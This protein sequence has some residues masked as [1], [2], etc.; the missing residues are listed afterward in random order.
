MQ[1]R[2]SHAFDLRPRIVIAFN[3]NAGFNSNLPSFE[4]KNLNR[5]RCGVKPLF[6]AS[7]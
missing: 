6:K 1:Q 3:A 5:S 2:L 7:T 4:T